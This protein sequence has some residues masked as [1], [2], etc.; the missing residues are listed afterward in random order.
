MRQIGSTSNPGLAEQFADHLR[1][2]GIACSVDSGDGGFRIWVH[3][4]DRVAAAKEEFPRFLADPSQDK[5][6]L[7]SQRATARLREQAEQMKAARAR[8]VNISEKWTRPAAAAAPLTFTVI[9]A[10]VLTAFA[11]GFVPNQT[12][13]V[14]RLWFSVDGTLNQI[15][16]GEVWRIISPIFLHM[17]ITHLVF[18]MLWMADFGRQIENRGGTWRLLLLIL[19]TGSLSNF[20]QYT[21]HPNIFF[22]GMS[23]VVYGLFGYIWVKSRMQPEA[24]YYMPQQTVV[25]MLAWHVLCVLGIIENVANWAH[26]GGLMVGIAIAFGETIVGPYVRRR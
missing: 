7:A 3:D 8:T 18:N 19:A 21:W 25:L 22:G 5:Y 10:S 11:T 9:G 17:T 16:N 2:E 23:G 6:R 15:R 24:G 13:V 1:A 4:D 14:E 12:D 26:G 20:A